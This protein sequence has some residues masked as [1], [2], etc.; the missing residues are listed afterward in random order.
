MS[1]E[2]RLKQVDGVIAAIKASRLDKGSVGSERL[3][4]REQMAVGLKALGSAVKDDYAHGSLY[5]RVA[6]RSKLEILLR[7]AEDMRPEWKFE[8]V[9]SWVNQKLAELNTGGDED[10]RSS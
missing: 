5:Q 3:E 9:N 10:G 1:G 8:D 6:Y 2:E 7:L 4:R